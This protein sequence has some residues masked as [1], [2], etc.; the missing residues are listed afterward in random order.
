MDQRHRRSMKNEPTTFLGVQDRPMTEVLRNTGS[1]LFSDCQTTIQLS[2]PFVSVGR[3]IFTLLED[4]TRRLVEGKCI[5]DGYVK[6]RS[7]KAITHS[8]GVLQGSDVMFDVVYKCSVCLP[9]A[10]MNIRCTAL[11]VTK[12]GI[13][14][15]SAD[16]SPSPVM[17]FV[18]RDL[19]YASPEF[20]RV[21][22]GS[23]F[24]ARVIGQRFELNDPYV[25]VIAEVIPEYGGDAAIA[26]KAIATK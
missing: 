2:I 1:A 11:E 26:T 10:G 9:V 4:T 12:G 13:R 3:D 17:V 14:A 24:V 25:S 7:V 16:E 21:T 22:P 15:T 20:S 19:S 18:A 6:P 23:S 8:A 5:P